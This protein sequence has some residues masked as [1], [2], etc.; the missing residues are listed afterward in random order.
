MLVPKANFHGDPHDKS[1]SYF[2][3]NKPGPSRYDQT[4]K[5][6]D[7]KDEVREKLIMANELLNNHY[8]FQEVL[9]VAE[10]QALVTCAFLQKSTVL[11]NRMPRAVE[12]LYSSRPELQPNVPL[13]TSVCF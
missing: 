13:L 1:C 11:S 8:Y 10:G 2:L 5:S 12:S 6:E 7:L 3:L 4:T 9:N